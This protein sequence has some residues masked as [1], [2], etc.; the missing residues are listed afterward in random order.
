MTQIQNVTRLLVVPDLTPISTN[1]CR[2]L[3]RT[4]DSVCT[5]NATFVQV[6]LKGGL[7]SELQKASIFCVEESK[8]LTRETMY[9]KINV[10]EPSPNH[11]CS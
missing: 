7:E 3:I 6:R 9:A 4:L 2:E 5:S 10:E 8:I 1:L 11:C